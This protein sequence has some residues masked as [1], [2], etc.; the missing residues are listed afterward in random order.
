MAVN[1]KKI[2]QNRDTR[3]V[4]REREPP[5]RRD[6]GARLRLKIRLGPDYSG[7]TFIYASTPSMGEQCP[8]CVCV[9]ERERERESLI[10]NNSP[11]ERERESFIRNNS[12]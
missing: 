9:R 10:R 1:I 11:R 12:P 8:L 4:S 6:C 7:G 5:S 2:K 3:G